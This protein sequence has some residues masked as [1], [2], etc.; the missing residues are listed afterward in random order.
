MSR[1]GV[2]PTRVVDVATDLIDREGVQAL[3]LAE[4]A[5]RLGIKTPSLY[6][7]V[8]G[9]EGLRRAAGLRAVH[10]LG[11]ACRAAAMGRAGD[12]ALCAIAIAYRAVA[13]ARPGTYALTQVARPGDT[14]WETAGERVLEPIL[15]A[16]AGM[17]VS[18]AA[19]IHATRL[20]RSALHG[21]VLLEVGNGFGMDIPVDDSFEHL[22]DG[23]IAGIASMATD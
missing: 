22:L 2:T 21:F 8:D 12:D 16:L 19:A 20:L 4:V 14:E 17:G 18:G 7:H 5:D 1:A 9:I 3:T 23:V 10:D 6:S 13:T 11:E 15:A